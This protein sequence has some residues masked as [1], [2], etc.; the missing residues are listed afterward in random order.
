MGFSGRR[1]CN[2][3]SK[4]STSLPNKK[5]I[6]QVIVLK[7]S[8]PL[9]PQSVAHRMDL[10][11]FS[12]FWPNC[13]KLS[14]FPEVPFFFSAYYCRSLGDYL[15]PLSCPK[16][17]MNCAEI[18][19]RREWDKL[20]ISVCQSPSSIPVSNWRSCQKTPV[21]LKQRYMGRLQILKAMLFFE[22]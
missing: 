10:A 9:R 17:R 8:A 1:W 4:N 14:W 11:A 21:L 15:E 19:P 5:W 2:F 13:L 22:I 7:I 16:V 12:E 6:G 3:K 18:R 20:E